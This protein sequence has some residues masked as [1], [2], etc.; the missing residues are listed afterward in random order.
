MPMQERATGLFGL[1]YLHDPELRRAVAAWEWYQLLSLFSLVWALILLRRR[2]SGLASHVGLTSRMQ[3]LAQT[4][5]FGLLPATMLWL[6][7][8]LVYSGRFLVQVGEAIA[9]WSKG[10]EEVIA[11]MSF[12][13]IA[14]CFVF[15][16]KLRSRWL[17]THG[18]VRTEH[19]KQSL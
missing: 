9:S 10:I 2:E 16:T 14:W 13:W 17:R 8:D 1:V 15:G 18:G 7:V 3:V 19:L 6:L 11:V 4:L 12:G 5:A